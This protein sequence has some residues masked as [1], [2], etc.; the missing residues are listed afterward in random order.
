M[1]ELEAG[2]NAGYQASE[3]RIGIVKEAWYLA[4]AGA[5]DHLIA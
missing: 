1:R 4:R 2:R 3:R 5:G